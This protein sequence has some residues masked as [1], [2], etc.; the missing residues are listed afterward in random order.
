M[1]AY[2]QL[3]ERSPLIRRTGVTIV[4]WITCAGRILKLQQ[5]LLRTG[6]VLIFG[7]QNFARNGEGGFSHQPNSW[8]ACAKARRAWRFAN[9]RQALAVRSAAATCARRCEPVREIHAQ[10]G[11]G[12]KE[13]IYN[14]ILRKSCCDCRS[15]RGLNLSGCVRTRS[16]R[17]MVFSQGRCISSVARFLFA[18]IRL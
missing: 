12:N 5:I 1:F 8:R 9:S 11:E 18:N 4:A 17:E 13:L 16:E 14:G 10:T 7:D 2:T 6:R 3:A 15:D